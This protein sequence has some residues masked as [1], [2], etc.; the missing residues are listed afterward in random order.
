M[1]AIRFLVD[2]PAERVPAGV[3]L[4]E[5]ARVM[6]EANVSCVLVGADSC[7]ATE[8]D[9]TRALAAGLGPEAPVEAVASHPI[10]AAADMS[11][12]D[13]AAIMLNQET[14][15]LVI[16]GRDGVESVVSLRAVMAVLLQAVT[17]HV[18]LESLRVAVTAPAEMWLG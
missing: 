13:A 16:D 14:R 8:R 12:V 9:L 18:W 7:I 2:R 10:R 3:S 11:I 1:S 4:G 6:R 5:V 15:H 17:P